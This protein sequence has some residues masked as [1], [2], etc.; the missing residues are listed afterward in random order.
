MSI[1]PGAG[2]NI[3]TDT[4]VTLLTRVN[5]IIDILSSNV[6]TANS[7][8]N[9]S[10]TSGNVHMTGF[11]AAN[12][13]SVATLSGGNNQST[14]V[15]PITSNV[16]VGNSTVNVVITFDTLAVGNVLT[17]T[18]AVAVGANVVL[19]AGSL[20]LGN[21][22]V[23]SVLTESSLSLGG[24]VVNS[25]TVALGSNVALT[26]TGLSVGNSTVNATVN[27][28][29]LSI[30]RID[31]ATINVAGVSQNST[32]LGVGAN[33]YM[34]STS[35]FV[36]N[37]TVNSVLS[38]A[39]L[40]VGTTTVNSS[41]VSVANVSASVRAAVGANVVLDLTGLRVGNS[42]VNSV[43]LATGITV[44]SFV[45]NSSGMYVGSNVVANTSVFR[46]GNSTVNV[47]VNSSAIMIGSGRALANNADAH[48]TA[49][50]TANAAND[51]IISSGTYTPTPIGGNFRKLNVNGAITFAVP[52]QAGDYTMIVKVTMGTGAGTVS[53]SPSYGL[54]DGDV[55]TTTAGHIFFFQVV[56]ID[57]TTN[58]TVRAFQ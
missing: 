3:S 55:I 2:I 43:V 45:G 31:V 38:A 6:V 57:G 42:T 14:A 17:N 7:S 29:V 5:T 56:K 1:S 49:G 52:T 58:L 24:S 35:H 10:V 39:G 30:G 25:G 36:G 12:N 22:T 51:G 34:N 40:S 9:G 23:N 28:T 50:Y 53:V 15:L 27:S 26:N 33:V 48:L 4:M 44:G 19:G 37:S 16:S 46:V 13:M 32:F 21:S 54:I 8:A 41:H 20:S 11:V 47:V 18:T